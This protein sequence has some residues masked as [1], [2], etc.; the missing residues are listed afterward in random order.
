MTERLTNTIQ[1]IAIVLVG[2][3]F[4]S[5]IT[6]FVDDA[7]FEERMYR[8]VSITGTDV[9]YMTKDEFFT[10]VTTLQNNI[11]DKNVYLEYNQEILK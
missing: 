7:R 6:F 11:Q 5:V 4:V 3:F 8:N 2:L 1:Y 9:S 10:A